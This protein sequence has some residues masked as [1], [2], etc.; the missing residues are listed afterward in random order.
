MGFQ[1]TCTMCHSALADLPAIFVAGL[2]ENLV[3]GY[4][5]TDH[6]VSLGVEEGT[7]WTT[8]CQDNWKCGV[9]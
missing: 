1:L 3:M 7:Y 9:G 5:L 6:F 8:R 2:L 4:G